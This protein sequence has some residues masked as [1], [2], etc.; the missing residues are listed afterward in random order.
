MGDHP[1]FGA[2]MSEVSFSCGASLTRAERDEV[3]RAYVPL[4]EHIARRACS[5]LPASIELDDIQSVGMI[6]LIDAIGK[7]R[8]EKGTQFKVYAEIRIRGA[9][10]DELRQQDWVPRS[11]RER[12]TRIQ[13]A[14]RTLIARLDRAPRPHE[15]AEELGLSLDEYHEMY[16][17]SRAHSISKIEDMRR[18]QDGGS[19]DPLERLQPANSADQSPEDY[20]T[21]E[22]QAFVTREALKQL[23]ERQ[24][25]VVSL[26]YFEEM[27]LKDIGQLLGVT[28]SRISQVLSQAHRSLRAILER[29]QELV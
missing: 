17:K 27:K 26:Y 24:R 5:R 14:E 22:D 10:M 16:K 15:M 6:G 20:V 9:I 19:R 13:R 28:E 7:Y 12:A 21:A 8:E 4:V 3:I 29:E 1:L 23:P 18:P 11:V 25:V 2:T